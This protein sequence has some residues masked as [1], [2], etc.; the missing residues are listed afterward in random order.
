MGEGILLSCPSQIIQQAK[1]TY[2]DLGK[3]F[4]D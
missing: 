3:A 4:E 1:F 2:S